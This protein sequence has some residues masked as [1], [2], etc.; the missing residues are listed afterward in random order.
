VEVGVVVMVS[1]VEIVEVVVVVG[2]VLMMEVI[3][4]VVVVNVDDSGVGHGCR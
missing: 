2:F 1:F 3:V 4:M